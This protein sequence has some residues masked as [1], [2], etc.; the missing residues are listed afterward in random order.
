MPFQREETPVNI[1]AR[2]ARWSAANWKKATFGWLAFVIASAALGQAVGVV[3]LTEPEQGTGDSARA[4]ATLAR[5]KLD[6]SATETVL[7]HSGRLTASE[8]AF[9]RVVARVTGRVKAMP[10]VEHVRSPFEH[11]DGG[12]ISED[13]H[14]VLV[15]FSMRGSSETA[16]DHVQPVI[17]AVAAVQRQSPGFTVS[18]FGDA[19]AAHALRKLSSEGFARAEKLSVPITFLIMLVAFGAFVAA[20][21]PVLLAFSAVL[22]S[23]GLA[24]VAS[25]VVHQSEATS[26]VMLL[27]GMAVGVDYSLFYLRREREE[28]RLGH[29]SA[30]ALHRAAATSGRAVLVSGFTVLIA[31]AGMLLTGSK[32][33]T[34]LGVGAMLVVFTAMVG[35]LTVLP[36]LLGRLGDEVEKGAVRG[37]NRGRASSRIWDLILTP[38]LRFPRGAVVLS[39][40]VL[41]VL[42]LPLFGM[43]TSFLSGNDI[44][45]RL[46]I[47]R[48]YAQIQRAF[49]GA[50]Q[51]AQVVVSAADVN[52]RPV[53]QALERMEHLAL[54]SG[55]ASQPIALRIN[56]AHTVAEVDIPQPGNGQDPT[57]MH[58]L[59][60]LRQ[61]VLPTTLGRVSGVSYAVGGMSAG[62]SDFN[63][64]LS[65]HAP[66]VFAFVLGLAFV[67]LL[68]TFRSIVIPLTSIILNLLSVGAAYGVLVWVFQDGHLE[69]L[70]GFHSNGAV[71]AWLPL[72]L[73][74]VLFGLSMDYH[75]FI[76]SRIKELHGRGAS[77]SDAVSSGIR[78]TAGTVTA[79]A[80]VMVAVFAIFA[81]L[82]T[83]D[84]KQLGVGLAVA[85]LVDAT[86]IR[87]VLLPATMTLLG[88]WNWY[89]PHWLG[90]LPRRNRERRQSLG[91]AETA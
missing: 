45:H 60:T 12:Q 70:L 44:P 53:R 46:Q 24:A 40:G 56:A 41:V 22:A 48:T 78:S 81:S 6:Q 59:Q 50:P 36:A 52:A 58:A 33:F 35:S 90:W 67:L 8:P 11:G 57:S 29:S 88:E 47:E 19:S 3:K 71:V 72:F 18:E 28:R 85:V 77:T 31:M 26:S 34:S 7:V 25:H 21:I 49:P 9:E 64:T 15:Q 39:S 80:A 75:V 76:V 74:P 84:I 42:A 79:A 10:Q 2:A 69:T 4:Q 66:L 68:I 27:M 23:S 13:D 61:R 73:F 20:G 63:Q 86:L 5:A 62:T 14:S 30:V 82:P 51:P 37:T 65:V 38:V 87:S 1:A 89:L 83:L 43:H 17:D 54:A 91:L 55:E 32:V 16:A